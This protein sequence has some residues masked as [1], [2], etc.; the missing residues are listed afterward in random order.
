MKSIKLRHIFIVSLILL[1]VFAAVSCSGLTL[2]S[3]NQSENA[4]I[5]IVFDNAA[6]TISP[7]LTLDQL[8]NFKLTGKK[9]GDVTVV[10]LG[11]ASGYATSTAL[12]GVTITLPDGASGCSWDLTLTAECSAGGVNKTYSSTVTKTIKAGQ[13]AVKFT[14][15]FESDYSEGTGSFSVTLDWTENT[16]SDGKLNNASAVLQKMDDTIVKNFTA[17]TINN[18]TVTVS[19][20]NIPAG[21]YRLKISLNKNDAQVACWQEVVK[22]AGGFSSNATRTIR[23]FLDSYTITYHLNNSGD[24]VTN[25]CPTTATV[26]SDLLENGAPERQGYTFINWYTDSDFKHPFDIKT[27]CANT[28]LYARWLDENN[29]H[30]A[31][32]ETIADRIENAESTS[33]S[34][35]FEIQVF[36]PFSDADFTATANALYERNEE[37]NIYIAL[38]FSEVQTD[39]EDF[40]Y[41]RYCERLAGISI[42]ASV[43]PYDWYPYSVGWGGQYEH[44]VN[45]LSFENASNLLYIYVSENNPSYSSI[46]GV[47]CN[48]SGTK[49]VAFPR[50][51]ICEN[52]TYTTPDSITIIEAKAFYGDLSIDTIIM[53]SN[54]SSL[55]S[56]CFINTNLN[57]GGIFVSFSDNTYTWSSNSSYYF[58]IEEKVN[59]D[60]QSY[61][62]NTLEQSYGKES[63]T[64]AEV[65]A[66][67]QLSD[68]TVAQ[69]AGT[70]EENYN[71]NTSEYNTITIPTTN[72]RT[73]LSF[74]TVPGKTYYV[75]YCDKEKAEEDPCEFTNVP[76]NVNF[77]YYPRL[78][79]YSGDGSCYI[80]ALGYSGNAENHFTAVEKQDVEN[81]AYVCIQ[82]YGGWSS[83]NNSKV[84]LLIRE[85]E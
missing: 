5:K 4:V 41:F 35:P 17:L 38:D 42:P 81:V 67:A 16:E 22:V 1:T 70:T 40:E 49:I 18:R 29:P 57:N 25:L 75:Y 19:D 43:L 76:D 51:K 62:M 73:W 61:G 80:D 54:I 82:E 60:L 63:K 58:N 64:F 48:K 56:E 28:D 6:R 71:L 30:L 32:K 12:T 36:G 66:E 84:Y 65:I 72:S 2:Q 9:S 55:Q 78:F 59:K 68:A 8:T 21:T 50:G 14:Y 79:F 83:N 52:G 53:G 37:N 44:G 31:T 34:N 39:V 7:E 27:L 10:T 26:A 13:N 77:C 23:D 33:A 20:T 69:G 24:T 3:Q 45:A 11:N 15:V 47:L 85:V 74:P 46:D